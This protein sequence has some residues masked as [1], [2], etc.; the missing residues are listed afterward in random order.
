[1]EIQRINWQAT[2]PIRHK[3]LWPGKPIEFCRVE[4]DE[5]GWHYGVFKEKQLISV[6]SLYPSNKQIR[7]RKF[8]TLAE[9]Q[10][11]GIG[12]QLLQHTLDIAKQQQMESYWCDAR[13][14]AIG[15]YQRFG[16]TTEGACFYKSEVAYIKMR[17]S[18]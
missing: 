16:L 3:V 10:G 17:K 7:L 6:A 2:L 14:S 18:L 5:D 9:H 11:Q 8:A 1:M 4:G 15:F 12:S 13:E